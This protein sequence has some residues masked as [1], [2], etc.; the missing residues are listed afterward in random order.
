MFKKEVSAVEEPVQQQKLENYSP[1][2]SSSSSADIESNLYATVNKTISASV[3]GTTQ[4][5]SVPH[6]PTEPD[7]TI[8]MKSA[9]PPPLPRKPP[10]ILPPKTFGR[11]NAPLTNE[12]F[13]PLTNVPNH[14]HNFCSNCIHVC[15]NDV[16]QRLKN[17]VS[18]HNN[19]RCHCYS[20]VNKRPVVPVHPYFTKNS[21][22]GR[23]S[24]SSSIDQEEFCLRLK[25]NLDDDDDDVQTSL[26]P[27]EQYLISDSK[28]FEKS[29]AAVTPTVLLSPT[30]FQIHSTKQLS[31]KPPV[32]P[33]PIRGRST[34]T[35]QGPPP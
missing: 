8:D 27:K 35:T 28:K 2:P 9:L 1:K 30:V 11:Q 24:P 15:Q 22:G 4:S 21:H 17:C 16:N 6:S 7:I 25:L 33:K 18:G 10:P 5:I 29:T 3:N 31:P 26:N 14:G 32:P 19:H 13:V 23:D 34:P 20:A 12:K